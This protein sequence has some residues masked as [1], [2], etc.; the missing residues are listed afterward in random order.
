MHLRQAPPGRTS[1]S[2]ETTVNP[3][4]PIH[5]DACSGSIHARNTISRCA[6]K[7]RVM[8]SSRSAGFAATLGLARL[9][10]MLPLLVFLGLQ[11]AQVGVQAIEALLPE[12]AIMLDPA[13]DVLEW[14]GLEP[15][16]PPLRFASA[17]DEA[18]ALQHL[19]VLGDGGHAHLEGLGQLRDRSL[20]R[21]EPSQD[22]PPGGIGQ[23]HTP[24]AKAG[25]R[26][27]ALYTPV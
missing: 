18:G 14:T 7:T 6:S 24:A 15:A 9:A 4:G 17:R 16:R 11:R 12:A 3:C 10:P 5:C 21:G 19:E 1:I 13:G 2:K 27:G 22:R 20:T 8:T 25:P 23:G 26:H